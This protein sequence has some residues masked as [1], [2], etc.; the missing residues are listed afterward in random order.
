MKNSYRLLKDLTNPYKIKFRPLPTLVSLVGNIFVIAVVLLENLTYTYL[1][2][3]VVLLALI[4]SLSCSITPLTSGTVLSLI[5]IAYLV[6]FLSN[7][8][9]L[10]VLAFLVV[11]N[12]AVLCFRIRKDLMKKWIWQM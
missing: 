3:F 12:G 2:V 6:Y 1:N 10:G 8:N 4:M 5:D 7:E 9:L 11:L